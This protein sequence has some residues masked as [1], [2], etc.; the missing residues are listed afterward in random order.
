LP[1]VTSEN[2]LKAI[3]DEIY[4]TQ[5]DRGAAII[6]GAILEE[7]L[8]NALKRRLIL[9]GKLKDA[10]FSFDKNGALADFAQKIDIGYAVGILKP[11]VREDLHNVRRIRNRFAHTIAP[12]DFQDSK[13]VGY[14]SALRAGT[15]GVELPKH[16]FL[17][18][19]GR[20][21]SALMLLSQLHI[22]LRPL[23]GMEAEIDEVLN[24]LLPDE[25]GA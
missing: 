19:F 21:A 6:S 14:C 3:Y 11:E 23:E 25:L 2:E 10:L 18:A 20:L 15:E 4:Q 12:I 16:R 1:D 13:I 9:T 8:T 5:T 17:I 22:Q 24:R 7:Y